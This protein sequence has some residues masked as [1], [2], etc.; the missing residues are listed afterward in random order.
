MK[1]R[2][3]LLEVLERLRGPD[4][5]AWDQRQDLAS[6]ARFLSDEVFEYV[7]AA[8]SGDT[9]RATEELSDLFYMLAYNWL[10]LSET[11]DVKFEELAERG[12]EL[13]DTQIVHLLTLGTAP[14]G[15]TGE[16]GAMGRT[17]R[18]VTLIVVCFLAAAT[19]APPIR[20]WRTN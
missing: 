12:A 18:R 7:D 10:I 17:R 11:H 2:A 13:A 6:A 4:G 8:A 3:E 14:Y 1:H 19:A 5:C 9:G 20:E 16:G 15:F